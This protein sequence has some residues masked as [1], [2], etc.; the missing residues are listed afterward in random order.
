[1]RPSLTALRRDNI[2]YGSLVATTLID[3][4]EG[5]NRGLTQLAASQLVERESTAAV[6][7]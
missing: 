5:R 7:T 6:Q 4:V 3:L 2:A 1:M